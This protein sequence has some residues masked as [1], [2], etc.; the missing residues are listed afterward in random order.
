[1]GID[2]LHRGGDRGVGLGERE[3]RLPSQPAEDVGLG[4]A[5]P[6]LDLG[7]VAGLPA[8]PS[9]PTRS[10]PPS[11][12]SCV[13]LGVVERGLVDR[14]GLSGTI[15]RTP[16]RKRN[17]HVSR[18]VGQPGSDRLGVG[19][20]RGAGTATKISASRTWPVAGSTIGTFLPE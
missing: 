12:R 19:E 1:V 18:S 2:A 3:E 17:R 16:P 10:E 14:A 5:D 4:E 9:T 7:F 20:A 6:C 11:C 8:S 15:R 13:D